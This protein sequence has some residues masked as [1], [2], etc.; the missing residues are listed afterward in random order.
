VSQQ[1]ED[2][3]R[4]ELKNR[5]KFHRLDFC[6]FGG[7]SESKILVENNHTSKSKPKLL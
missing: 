4:Q 1:D 3:F 7:Q 5:F 6:T 2:K